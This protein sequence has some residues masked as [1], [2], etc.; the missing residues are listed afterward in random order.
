M[1]EIEVLDGADR[2]DVSRTEELEHVGRHNILQI[3][4]ESSPVLTRPIHAH[5]E[6]RRTRDAKTSS[7]SRD[8]SGECRQYRYQHRQTTE[9]SKLSNSHRLVI[10]KSYHVYALARQLHVERI[11]IRKH[12][13]SSSRRSYCANHPKIDAPLTRHGQ[14]QHHS[15][16][17]EK[18]D[19]RE[20]NSRSRPVFKYPMASMR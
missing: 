9:L 16:N 12:Q 8:V 5:R 1:R 15:P 7:T 17:P 3:K 13:P 2:E 14:L 20:L 18:I 4:F 11:G 6:R 10:Q 19:D